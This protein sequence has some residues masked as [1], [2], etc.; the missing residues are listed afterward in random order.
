MSWPFIKTSRKS[1]LVNDKECIFTKMAMNFWNL[2]PQQWPVTSATGRQY[3]QVQKGIRQ[4]P[5][6]QV[7][8]QTVQGTGRGTPPNVPN[9]RIVDAEECRQKPGSSALPDQN[10]LWVLLSKNSGP[11]MNTDV[12]HLGIQH[13][14][15]HLTTRWLPA[16]GTKY[17]IDFHGVH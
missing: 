15:L 1:F 5:R 8:K 3:Q 11:D 9:T 13:S 4:I 10:I 7:H 17:R 2:L 12:T 14:F 16:Q 6:Q